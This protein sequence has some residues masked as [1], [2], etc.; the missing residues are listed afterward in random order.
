M[1]GFGGT[2][3]WI[4]DDS[5]SWIWADVKMLGTSVDAMDQEC[6]SRSRVSNPRTGDS[7]WFEL[8][9]VEV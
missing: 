2:I 1:P 7:R 6:G 8:K 9:W 4:D 5:W 3:G